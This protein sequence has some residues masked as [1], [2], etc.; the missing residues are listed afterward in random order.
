MGPG[1]RRDD[2]S[3]F[4]HLISNQR[5][6]VTPHSRGMM[7]PSFYKF[8][9]PKNEAAGDPQGRAQGDPKRDAGR[10]QEGRREDRVHAAPAVSCARWI[11]GRTRAYR[12]S[13]G[14]PAFPA[15]WCY[16]LLRALPGDRA[17]LPP[18]LPRSLLL[19]SLTPAS[20]CQNHTTSPSASGCVRLS[21]APR[22]PHPA[23]NVR[24]DRDTPLQEGTRQRRIKR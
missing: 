22:P 2:E 9:G 18:S 21:Q 5:E 8:F 15:R 13:G 1:V 10:S 12:F 6:D 3:V 16:G 24:D 17:F 14:N 7:C 4:P 19:K 20:R 11:E 23:P